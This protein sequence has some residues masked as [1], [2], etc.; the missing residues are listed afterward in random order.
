MSTPSGLRMTMKFAPPGRTSSSATGVVYGSG[1]NH[2]LRSSGS[3]HALYTF[4]GGASII[5]VKTSSRLVESLINVSSLYQLLAYSFHYVCLLHLS[6]FTVK[7]NGAGRNRRRVRNF[8]F[9]PV[10]IEE[11]LAGLTFLYRVRR[12]RVSSSPREVAP[13]CVLRNRRLQPD[14]GPSNV[15]TVW[16]VTVGS[17]RTGRGPP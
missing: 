5:R 1:A 7:S 4:S 6:V 2:R 16:S 9:R 13:R 14:P 11:E 3:V 10:K 17:R 8:L 15:Y 12:R